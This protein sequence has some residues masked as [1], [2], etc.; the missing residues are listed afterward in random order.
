MT[1][2]DVAAG[3]DRHA[4][5]MDDEGVAILEDAHLAHREDG[6]DGEVGPPGHQR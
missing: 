2:N 6:L 1:E 4:P 3:V 5:T